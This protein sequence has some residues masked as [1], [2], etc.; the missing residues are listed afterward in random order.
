MLGT[1]R[2]RSHVHARGNMMSEWTKE[3]TKRLVVG[4]TRD[5][6]CIYDEQAKRELI[7]ACPR[8]G[9]PGAEPARACGGRPA[10]TK[11]PG[12]PGAAA[13]GSLWKLGGDCGVNANQLSTWARKFELAAAKTAAAPASSG[14]AVTQAAFV[15]VH[16]DDAPVVAQSVCVDLQA[17]LPNGVVVDLRACD[18]RQARGL[19]DA[20]GRLQCSASTKS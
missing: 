11:N 16:I 4:H 14:T 3:L 9:A 8:P 17:R 1:V 12:P 10:Q 6:R 2:L 18:M 20:L 13:G 5:G 15:A 19:L 7:L